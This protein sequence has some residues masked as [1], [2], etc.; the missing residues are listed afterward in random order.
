MQSVSAFNVNKRA[1][2]L[3]LEFMK[4]ENTNKGYTAII[5]LSLSLNSALYRVEAY[6]LAD[7]GSPNIVVF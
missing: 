1:K 5:N 7:P 4:T 3:K 6:N 2:G